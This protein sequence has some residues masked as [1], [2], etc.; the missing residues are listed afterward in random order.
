MFPPI[1]PIFSE[2]AKTSGKIISAKNQTNKQ[3][4]DW[5]VTNVVQ[6]QCTPPPS[7]TLG[8]TIS[9]HSQGNRPFFLTLLH[10]A[11]AGGCS[12]IGQILLN[13]APAT[14][15]CDQTHRRKNLVGL[16]LA[17]HALHDNLRNTQ[18]PLHTIPPP[19]I[20]CSSRASS[21]CQESAHWQSKQGTHK[22]R[23]NQMECKVPTKLQMR[24]QQSCSAFL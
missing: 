20:H 10:N 14:F 18:P 15:L 19:L 11:I 2:I 24:R 13:C 23:N 16:L 1:F 3:T 4:T 6:H 17:N 22:K 21:A 9:F 12:S 8:P 7:P 5:W